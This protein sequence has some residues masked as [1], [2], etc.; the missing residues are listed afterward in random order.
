MFGDW[1]YLLVIAQRVTRSRGSIRFTHMYLLT[2]RH[3]DKILIVAGGPV[4]VIGRPRAGRCQN[5]ANAS[6]GR[7]V[8]NAAV[9]VSHH[10]PHLP[11]AVTTS[12]SLQLLRCSARRILLT[13][14]SLRPAA[15]WS[16][17]FRR[18]VT[19]ASIMGDAGRRFEYP[20]A[21][22]GDVVD[23]HHGEKVADPYRWLEDPDAAE[24]KAWVTAQ[25]KVTRRYLDE[26]VGDVRSRA[27]DRLKE[28]FTY[29]KWGTPF[30]R[31]E[32]F[33]VW[34][35]R[36]LQNQYILFQ[37]RGG[38][39]ADETDMRV[40]IDPNR[41]AEDGTSSVGQMAFSQDGRFVAY[42]INEAG[43]DW[44]TIYVTDTETGERLEQDV[45]KWAKFYSLAWR[46]DGSGFY[47]C[48]F[49]AP[50]LAEGATAG[51]E[52]SVVRG[53][54]LM[55][56][57]LRT[58]Q[59]EDCVVH[60][61]PDHPKRLFGV[62]ISDDGRYLFRSTAEDCAP[63]N[64]VHYADLALPPPEGAL[65]A[66]TWIP[67][68]TTLDA[69]FSYIANNGPR[70]LLETNLDAPRC[71]VVSL[72]LS[73]PGLTGGPAASLP[74][75]ELIPQHPVD[76]LSSVDAVNGV[77]GGQLVLVH[78]HDVH[79]VLSVHSMASGERLV[80]IPTPAA[81]CVSVSARRRDDFFLFKF[82]SFLYPGSIFHVDVPFLLGDKAPP[83]GVPTSGV[84]AGG[85]NALPGLRLWREM[86]VPGFD[87]AAY[88][89]EQ[90]FYP[91]KDGTKI[92]AFIVRRRPGVDGAS[93]PE[94]TPCLLYGYGGFMISIMPYFSTSWLMWI[95]CFRGVLVIAN[96]RG[97]SEVRDDCLALFL[98]WFSLLRVM[99]LPRFVSVAAT[100]SSLCCGSVSDLR[101][102]FRLPR[103]VLP[104]ILV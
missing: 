72:D 62:V 60:A 81:G 74:L 2:Q 47:Y 20:P 19:V 69:S 82:V 13:R 34:M 29:D 102:L 100:A 65:G 40:L 35:Q 16:F 99:F 91:S 88:Q 87:A 15:P 36:G 93:P 89:T 12:L 33:Y 92:P 11:A 9:R 68:V 55:F 31:G 90:V 23:V 1:A 25:N 8:S 48:R 54:R 71:R 77:E 96:I 45:L 86:T 18:G 7:S 79:D 97:G 52:T 37:L 78:R 30:R 50:V 22:K 5:N 95:Q 4:C 76:V 57:A 21:I 10:C 58:P 6:G 103:A 53:Q 59:G 56:H 14:P 32:H 38:L 85:A 3:E 64:M 28:T 84:G 83:S 63:V 98:S 27:L 66:V 104:L 44:A 39:D 26:A 73:T 17:V 61:E 42:G 24:T 80:E 70:V 46:H 43:S 75:K 41:L 49:D 94:E 101:F 67:L 51:T